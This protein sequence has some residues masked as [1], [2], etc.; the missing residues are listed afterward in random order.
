MPESDTKVRTIDKGEA[1]L[2][3]L[4]ERYHLE[5]CPGIDGDSRLERVS[6]SRPRRAVTDDGTAIVM[7]EPVALIRCI[8]C[9][10]HNRPAPLGA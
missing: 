2:L 4:A 7:H 9:G 1:P 5:G 6:T 8:D 10:G 3:A